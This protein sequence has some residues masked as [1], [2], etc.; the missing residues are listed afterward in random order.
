MRA[1]ENGGE[2]LSPGFRAHCDKADLSR[3][4]A[5]SDFEYAR[6]R[7][8]E[9]KRFNISV[10]WL[11][12]A[13]AEAQKKAAAQSAASASLCEHWNTEPNDVPEHGGVLLQAL[14]ERI[15]RH[16]VMTADQATVA[17]LW[18]LLTWVHDKAVVHSPLFLATSPE[19]NSGKTTLLGIVSLLVRNSLC[20]V[21]I[22]GPA[23]FRS[24]EKWQ[25]TFVIDEADDALVDNQDLKSVINSGWTRGSSV[26]RCDPRLTT[27]SR[28]RRSARRLLA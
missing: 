6:L 4:A 20:S 8:A 12:K 10:Q 1:P 9:A 25:P 11:D 24:I 5:L 17:A 19:A 22:S 15:R 16:V 27:Q 18:V 13:R 21:S 3:V 28:I 23:L 7:A 26:I 14:I 2:S